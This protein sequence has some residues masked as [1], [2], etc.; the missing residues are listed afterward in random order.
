M[1]YD[2][3]A[4][5]LRLTLTPGVGNVTAR[6]LLHHFGPPPQVFAQSAV[7]LRVCV[8]A[9]QSQALQTI[10]P[11]L[12]PLLVM[13]KA[14]LGMAA[15]TWPFTTFTRWTMNARWLAKGC[16]GSSRPKCA[17]QRPR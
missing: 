14:M 12:P 2:E 8:S 6:K 15:L 1:E 7:A 4:A 11:A 5:W 10:P 16:A 17:A 13:A 9:T 3:L